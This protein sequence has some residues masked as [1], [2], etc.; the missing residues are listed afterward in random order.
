M[1]KRDLQDFVTALLAVLANL[2]EY[3]VN[4]WKE[5]GEG[6]RGQERAR[7]ED[8]VLLRA[9]AMSRNVKRPTK[10][11]NENYW[12]KRG[13]KGDRAVLRAFAMS[14]TSS[15]S[16]LPIYIHTNAY[17]HTYIH[18][19]ICIL[20]ICVYAI[21]YIYIHIYVCDVVEVLEHEL[22]V[23]GHIKCL[24]HSGQL[25]GLTQILKSQYPS[26]FTDTNS[27]KSYPST[28]TDTKA[29][30]PHTNAQESVP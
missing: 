9:L 24:D 30:R 28:F 14:C 25:T 15:S 6:R 3:R 5:A 13:K 10:G 27:Q 7:G 18:T 4:G 26:T 19:Y 1:S 16:I 17:T 29:H 21:Y 22:T 8:L 23:L 20:H 2:F 11:R 12:K